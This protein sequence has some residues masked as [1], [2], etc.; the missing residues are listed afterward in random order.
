MRRSADELHE[1]PVHFSGLLLL[2]EVAAAREGLDL[3]TWDE[4]LDARHD[5]FVAQRAILQAPDEKRRDRDGLVAAE[6]AWALPARTQPRPDRCAVPADH[7]AGASRFEDGVRERREL[8]PSEM[9]LVHREG[10]DHGDSSAPPAPGER[11][12][13]QDRE[14]KEE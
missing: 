14:L 12:L 6:R 8:L 10:T 7:R 11:E 2:H 13:G 1:P 3:D 5:V 4:P 9:R